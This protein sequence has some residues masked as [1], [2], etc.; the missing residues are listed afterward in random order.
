MGGR[1]TRRARWCRSC[2]FG[3]VSAGGAF[4]ANNRGRAHFV[5]FHEAFPQAVNLFA[6]DWSRVSTVRYGRESSGGWL[7]TVA[8]LHQVLEHLRIGVSH[9]GGS[10]MSSE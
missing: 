4:V 2:P 1:E 7:P 10:G 6:V 9:V 8:A 3:L 5:E